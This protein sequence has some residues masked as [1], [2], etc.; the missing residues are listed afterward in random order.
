MGAYQPLFSV[1]VEHTYFTDHICK[2]LKFI[3]A[4]PSATVLNKTGLLLKSSESGISVFYEDD[5][6]NRL[7]LHAEDDLSLVFKVFSKDPNFFRYTIPGAQSD[8]NLLFFN[9]Q[10]ITRDAAD[11]QMLH[12]DLNATEK[13]LIDMRADQLEGMLDPK[14]YLVKPAFILQIVI[15]ADEQGLCSEKLDA[16]S[17]RYFIRFTTSQT[18]WKYYILGDLSKKNL[19]IT[20]LDNE[21]Q[22]EDI[23]NALLPGCREAVILQSKIAIRMQEKHNQRFQLRESGSMGDK[24]L[25]KRMPTA[26]VSN[27]NGEMINGRMEDVSEI[28]IN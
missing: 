5:K 8:S 24:V 4:G 22:F 28:Y 6:I 9:N 3:P 11:K 2:A 12:S 16:A 25:I 10:Q 20:D 7:R 1:S 14:D 27:I 26:C 18:Y 21:I 19:Y 15:T 13:A 23:G 17:R